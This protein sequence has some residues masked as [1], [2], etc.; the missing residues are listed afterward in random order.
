[1]EWMQPLHRVRGPRSSSEIYGVKRQLD[2]EPW[3]RRMGRSGS[4]VKRRKSLFRANGEDLFIL[5]FELNAQGRADVTSLHDGSTN[6]DTSGQTR[7]LQGIVQGMS[8][9]IAYKRMICR[10]VA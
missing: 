1:M 6:P 5:N 7:S 2:L 3:P 10:A 8:A 9:R 4:R